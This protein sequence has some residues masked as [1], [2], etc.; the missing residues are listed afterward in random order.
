MSRGATLSTV[1]APTPAISALVRARVE[2][3]VHTYEHDPSVESYGDE[4]VRAMG[5]EAGRVFKTLV[6]STGSGLVVAV[7]PVPAMLDMKALAMA[8]GAKRVEMA[9]P[10]AAER[11]TGY[12]VG[13]ISPI[14]QK[15]RLA[16]VVDESVLEWETIFCS[17]GRRGLEVELTPRA[18]L[19]V[20]S[21]TAASVARGR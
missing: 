20:T 19:E 9:D 15:R 16:T 13:A 18:L 21:G 5:V 6:T 12:L 1:A 2:H 4:A 11:S 17:A 10:A 14:G 8:I 3:R 7:V